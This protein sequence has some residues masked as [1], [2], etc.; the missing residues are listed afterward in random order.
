MKRPLTA[1]KRPLTAMKRLR[2]SVRLLLAHLVVAAVGTLTAYLMVRLL[3]PRLFDER[4]A[5]MQRMAGQGRGVGRSGGPETRLRDVLLPALD[6]ALVIGFVASALAA[7]LA[8]VIYTRRLLRPLDALRHAT[9]QIAAGRYDAPAQ[10]PSEP[11]LAALATDI[12]TLA[13]TLAHTET[14]RT[15]LLGEVAHEM[16][17]PLT[18]LD[19]YVEG[20]IDGVFTA[21]PD[22]LASLSDEL[23]RLHRL[24][25]DL[26]GLSRA[27]EG[28][29]GLTLVDVDLAECARRAAVRLSPQ[30]EDARVT[31][32]IETGPPAPAHADPD[33]IMQVLTNLLGNAL[34]ATPAGGTVTI[35]TRLDAGQVEIA[36]SDTGVGLA[37]DDLTRVFE[38]FYRAPGQQRRSSGSGVGLTIAREIARRHGGD[39]TASSA[40]L[41]QG[42]RF[43]L[44]LPADPPAAAG[45][46]RH[47]PRTGHTPPSA[48]KSPGS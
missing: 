17:T 11:E 41:G 10:V 21:S 45:R 28:R 44:T 36:V 5:H 48:V 23:R 1:M 13:R 18:A 24:A 27:Q 38:R 32:A 22:T 31:L 19:G 12:N 30:F 33:R 40:G 7:A 34:L 37:P 26:S 43:T 25:D 29:L 39:I 35:A 16:R 14:R 47:E 3:T 2:L 4:M 8:A 15:R 6:T 20:L 46:R 9:R 42:A